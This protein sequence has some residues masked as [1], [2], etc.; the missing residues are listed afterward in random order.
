MTISSVSAS[1]EA[2]EEVMTAWRGGGKKS[3]DVGYILVLEPR[4]IAGLDVG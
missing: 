1:R 3:L 2:S 4:L